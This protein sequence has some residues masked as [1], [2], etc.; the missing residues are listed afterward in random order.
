MTT[1]DLRAPDPTLVRV[2]SGGPSGSRDDARKPP[3]S[4][5]SRAGL[6]GRTGWIGLVPALVLM[7]AFVGFSI[8]QAVV[9]SLSDWRGIGDVRI[10][11][12][13][14]YVAVLGDADTWSSLSLTFGYALV[15]SVGT[16]AVATLLAASVSAGVPGSSFYRVIWFLPGIAPGAAV[17]IFWATAFQPDFGAVN[18]VAKLFGASGRSALLAASQ[19]AIIPVVLVTVWASV[20]FAFLLLLGGI[21]Q[22][23]ATIYEAARVDGATGIRQFFLITLPLTRPVIVTTTFLNFIW[24][25]NGFTTVWSMTRGGP[26]NATLTFPVAVY[27]EAF[28]FADYGPASALALIGGVALLIVG[29]V[30]LRFSR[31]SQ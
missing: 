3:K 27:K 21:E 16:V 22:I 6:S 17:G 18:V 5:R 29:F 20:G 25:F 12:L 1:G 15:S 28:Q 4:R 7:A 11:G 13:D 2:G 9:V 19:T 8:V 23:P 31:S 10:I 26:G 30:G 24:S 14:N